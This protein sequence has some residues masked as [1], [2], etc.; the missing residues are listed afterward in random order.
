[1]AAG[2]RFYSV[3]NGDMTLIT[4]ESGRVILVDVNIREAA[5]DPN[6]ETP[7][8]FSA[9]K[10]NLPV[11]EYGRP[12]VDA[13]LLT[14]PDADH[15]RGLEAHF[16]LGSPEE[17]DDTEDKVF[18]R[19]MWSS[20]IIFRRKQDIDG[21]LCMDAAAWWGEARRRV[22]LYKRGT[23]MVDGN[24]ILILGEDRD[25]KTDDITEIVVQGESIFTQIAGRHDSSFRGALLGPLRASDEEESELLAKNHSSVIMQMTIAADGNPEACKVLL[26]GDAEV[27]I[28]ERVWSRYQTVTEYLEY[29][30]MLAPHHC[31][32]RTLS[33]DSWS[34]SDGTAEPCDEALSA[35]SQAKAGA[36]I[37]ASSKPI[38]DD[39]DDP[40][41]IGAK[42]QYV[43]ITERVGGEFYCVRET[44]QN[45]A[46]E[47]L[48]GY[49]GPYLTEREAEE[50]NQSL[51]THEKRVAE[52]R[53]QQ[54][55]RVNSVGT[56]G[57][58]G[59]LVRQN[60]FYGD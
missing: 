3:D 53:Q 37:I 10:E 39:H 2:I 7:D 51:L 35:L 22:N 14:H 54:T 32:W 12:Y 44:T 24:R 60:T 25:G 9:L 30:I 17:Y 18:I 36:F 43:A 28:W 21:E 26:G 56:V 19:E 57:V 20:P 50:V 59:T 45:E 1:M 40:P 42:N 23:L 58:A 52:A 5:D 34:K 29:N 27:A 47:F 11:D 49:N 15:C 48:I 31:S 38:V 33:Y 16:H 6:D 41:C 4:L 46:L 13:F 55:L 8:V